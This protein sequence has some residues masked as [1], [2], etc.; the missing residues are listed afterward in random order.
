MRADRLLAV[1]LLLQTRGKMTAGRLADELGVSRRTILR[2]V[3]ALSIAG[4]P[5]YSE[6]GHGGGIALDEHYRT[7]LTGLHTPELQSLFVS[8]NTPAL[9]DVGLGAASESLLLKLLAALP[10]AQRPAV[11]HLRQRLMVDPAW[12]WQDNQLPA[13]WDDLQQAVYEDR[14]IETTYEHYDG[15]IVERTLRPYSLISKSSLWY[16]VAERG[17]D[18]RTYR[19]ARFHSLRLLDE[20]FTRRPDFDLPTYWR[21]HLQ[22]FVDHF[23]EYGCTLRIH[24]ERLAFVRWLMPGRWQELGTADERGWVTLRLVMDSILMAKMLVFSLGRAAE[25]LDPPDLAAAVL[26]D[27]HDLMQQLGTAA[28]EQREP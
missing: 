27:A 8:G 3:D 16:L 5:I 25:I 21:E 18:M 20:R 2:D 6:G 10:A 12:W 24:P 23:S 17:G 4:I 14:V 26:A 15:S 22:S 11:D 19:V 7:T 1:L 13:F 9:R 28:S